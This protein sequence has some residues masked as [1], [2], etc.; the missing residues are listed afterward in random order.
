MKCINKIK[1]YVGN[2]SI[3]QIWDMVIERLFRKQKL[4]R[5]AQPRD[6]NCNAKAG[7]VVQGQATKELLRNKPNDIYNYSEPENAEK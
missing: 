2:A 3:S 5:K 1:A 4:E 6:L 7:P